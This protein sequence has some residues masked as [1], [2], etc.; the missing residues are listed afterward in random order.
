MIKLSKIAG[1]LV[2]IL[3][4][5]ASFSQNKIERTKRILDSLMIKE[6]IPGLAYSVIKDG[7]VISMQTLGKSSIPFN[8]DVNYNTAFQLASVSKIYTAILLGKLFDEGILKPETK[9]SEVLDSIPESWN[10]ITILELSAHQSGIK[11]GNISKARNSTE[12]LKIAATMPFEFETGYKS[13]YVSSDYWI[14]LAVVEKVTG[15]SF[16]DAL[17][18]Y[19]LKSLLLENTYVNNPKIGYISDLDIIPHQAQEYHWFPEE[20]KLRINQLWFKETDY[21]AGGIY[22][23][24][25]DMTKIAQVFDKK[26]FLKKSTYDLIENPIK[27][28][29][30]KNGSYGLALIVRDYEGHKIIEHS[31]GPA[32]ADFV[33][34]EKEGFTF[35]VLTNNRG[36][37]PC[38]AKAIATVWIDGLP[39]PKIPE[40]WK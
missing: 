14:L 19:V 18:Q 2:C 28:K 30:G 4:S 21:A 16:Y 22:S 12:A 29:D 15:L 36:V 7:K 13:S 34:F 25:T 32:L 8:V 39:F 9:L 27:L 35:I 20:N 5:N 37:Y 17:K 33:K 3:I 26:E 6:H 38:L 11:M 31:G 1:F 40:D 23:S 10:N 24:I